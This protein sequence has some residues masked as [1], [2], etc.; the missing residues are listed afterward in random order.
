[1]EVHRVPGAD[2]YRD[3]TRVIGPAATVAPQ[4]FADVTLALTEVFA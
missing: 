4:A 3:V 1:M 2:G